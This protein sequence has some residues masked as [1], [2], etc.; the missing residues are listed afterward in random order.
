MTKVLHIIS[1]GGMYGAEAVILNLSRTLN[2]GPHR[3]MLGVFSNLSQP[4]LQLYEIAAKQGIEA[5]TISCQGQIDRTVPA[6][7]RALV[8]QTGAT[9][10]HA[11]G[12]KA[13]IYVYLAMRGSQT[14]IVSTCHT[15]YDNDVTVRIYGALDR[16]VL[17]S[18]TGV[19]AVSG[20]VKQRLLGSGVHE[21]RIHL[22]RN[23]IDLRPFAASHSSLRDRP[24]AD[25]PLKIGL[26]GRLAPEK[27]VD[28]FLRAAA[29][30]LVEMPL[31]QFVVVGDGP[32]RAKLQSLIDELG[33]GKNASLSGRNEDMPSFYASLDLL[34]SS[35][36]QEGLPIALLEGMASGLPLIATAVGAVPTVVQDGRTGLLV[37]PENP[38]ELT[39]AIIKL[40]REP[41]TRSSYGAAARALIKQEY[42]AERMT[43]EY[44]QL[45]QQAMQQNRA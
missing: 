37:P 43:A 4:N 1:S 15:W 26:V 40:L 20:E 31:T 24:E 36:R 25:G 13:D 5:H 7:I 16:F 41:A 29:G 39:A 35:S 11:H 23:G 44:L 10:V 17:R 34:V 30:V 3:S 21:D 27:G 42:S 22:I 33:I 14:P 18:Y 19:V 12:Y 9:V 28:I 32:D 38:Q 8:H 45:Y 2:E 6:A